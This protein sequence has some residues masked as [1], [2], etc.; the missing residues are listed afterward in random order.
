MER[1][2]ECRCCTVRQ[3]LYIRSIACCRAWLFRRFHLWSVPNSPR[4]ACFYST[5]RNQISSNLTLPRCAALI[6]VN[7][8]TFLADI[9]VL[10]TYEKMK[11]H[12]IENKG[13][14]RKVWEKIDGSR[15]LL[16]VTGVK[17]PSGFTNRVFGSWI[18]WQR[19]VKAD[20]REYF[21]VGFEDSLKYDGSR[22]DLEELSDSKNFVTG[23]SSGVHIIEEVRKSEFNFLHVHFSQTVD[24]HTLNLTLVAGHPQHVQIY[25][26]PVCRLAGPI[27]SA[28]NGS[29]HRCSV[30]VEL[31]TSGKILAQR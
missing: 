6:D 8:R 19:R 4:S 13:C 16:Y 28:N 9:W 24:A 17:F 25:K 15:G 31:P 21:I 22:P 2:D 29:S 1:R 23:Y 26:D 18:T 11:L 7:A 5:H 10:G 12:K 20:G 30:P 3:P 14:P 27:S